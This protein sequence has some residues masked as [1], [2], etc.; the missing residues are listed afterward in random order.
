MVF[1]SLCPDL[2]HAIMVHSWAVEPMAFRML[3]AAADEAQPKMRVATRDRAE[4]SQVTSRTALIQ[5]RG[6]ITP[7]VK[8]IAEQLGLTISWPTI[9]SMIER[10]VEDPEID[11]VVL[12]ID[13]PGGMVSGSY[14]AAEVLTQ[15]RDDSTK[16][17]I[18]V[19]NYLM[20]S[21]AYWLAVAAAHEIVS[22]QT[23]LTGSIGVL[24]IHEDA[25]GAYE[26]QGIKLELISA[27]R[28]KAEGNDT[29]PLTDAARAHMQSQVDYAYGLFVNAVASARGATAGAVRSGYGQGRV[30]TATAALEENLIDRVESLGSVFGRLQTAQ[31]RAAAKRRKRDKR[32]GPLPDVSDD[33]RESEGTGEEMQEVPQEETLQGEDSNVVALF[34]SALENWNND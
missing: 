17:I 14:E 28:Y 10:A 11:S 4:P 29:E 30:L 25:S 32:A 15:I 34:E 24:A 19:S 6:L 12:D 13:S 20:A 31:G 33:E 23:A 9:T 16:P 27:G 21:G 5:I 26:Q 1:S 8:G 3:L 22:A 7:H 2:A 18:A